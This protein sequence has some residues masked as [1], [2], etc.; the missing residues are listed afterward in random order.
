VNL[1]QESVERVGVLTGVRSG[2]WLIPRDE[3]SVIL[4]TDVASG[5]HT[6]V[7]RYWLMHWASLY[8]GVRLAYEADT[9]QQ[10][11]AVQL[12]VAAGL[13]GCRVFHKRTP[14]Y[15]RLYI[16]DIGNETNQESSSTTFLQVLMSHDV[17]EAAWAKK[18]QQCGWT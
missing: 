7:Q 6:S 10:I 12:S 8:E 17:V 11:K 9:Q 14:Q 18:R 16:I 4:A 3:V 2:A 1:A 15:V 5:K 13:S